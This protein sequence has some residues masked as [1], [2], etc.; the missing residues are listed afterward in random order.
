MKTGLLIG[1]AVSRLVRLLLR[2]VIKNI[3]DKMHVV[4]DPGSGIGVAD[5][6]KSKLP[7]LVL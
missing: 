7:P 5:T 1:V 4:R 2:L 6:R 3:A